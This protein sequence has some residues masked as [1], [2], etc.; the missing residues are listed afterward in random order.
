VIAVSE[1]IESGF[2]HSLAHLFSVLSIGH[3]G[4][5]VG[6]LWGYAIGELDCG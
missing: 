5:F 3:L 6:G 1:S 2:E 4:P